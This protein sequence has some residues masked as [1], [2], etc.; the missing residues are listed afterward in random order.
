MP[1]VKANS[2]EY[3]SDEAMKSLADGLSRIEGHVRAVKR[4]VE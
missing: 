3:L 4:M 2:N 1:K